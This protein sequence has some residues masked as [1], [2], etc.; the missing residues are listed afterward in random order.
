M[1]KKKKVKGIL[2]FKDAKNKF[3]VG[4]CV[5]QEREEGDSRFIVKSKIL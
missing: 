4:D 2:Q 1:G 3:A 5:T